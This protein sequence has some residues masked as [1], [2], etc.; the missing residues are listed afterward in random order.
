[1]NVKKINPENMEL[2]KTDSVLVEEINSKGILTLNRPKILNA[3]NHEMAKQVFVALNKWQN[4]KSMIII[5]GSGDKAFCSGSDL[6]KLIDPSEFQMNMRFFKVEYTVNYVIANLKIPYVSL[7][8]GIVMGA[9]V[10]YSIHGRYRIATERTV[11][12]MPEPWIGAMPDIGSSFFL[13]RLD[14]K[15]GFYLGLTGSRL[16][17]KAIF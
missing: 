15:L 10:G 17:G 1:M 13:P 14:G 3:V 4:T 8:D 6:K 7:I 11:F 2:P 5:K 16:Y 12:A 9:G